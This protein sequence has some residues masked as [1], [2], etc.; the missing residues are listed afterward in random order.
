MLVRVC[1]IVHIWTN[2]LHILLP[3]LRTAIDPDRLRNYLVKVALLTVRKLK[4]ICNCLQESFEI[5]IY[6]L[7][8]TR[9]KEEWK[10]SRW[11]V[12]VSIHAGG[13]GGGLGW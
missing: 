3:F 1:L 7:N 6:F 4:S 9:E 11:Q 12:V 13:G 10:W 8:K 2:F 5:T